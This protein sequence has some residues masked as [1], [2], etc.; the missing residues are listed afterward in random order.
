MFLHRPILWEWG[1]N[2]NKVMGMGS[3][4]SFP[5]ICSKIPPLVHQ[6]SNVTQPPILYTKYAANINTQSCLC[7]QYILHNGF[8]LL[9]HLYSR[10]VIYL[11]HEIYV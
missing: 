9:I 3:K 7:E 10:H 8:S 11:R 1:G 4:K 5:P 6:Q 2:R